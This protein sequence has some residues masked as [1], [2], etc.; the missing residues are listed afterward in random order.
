MIINV[1]QV[2]Y[3]IKGKKIGF[4]KEGFK[5]MDEEVVRVVRQVVLILEEVGVE[6]FD[7]FFFIYNDGEFFLYYLIGC[8]VFFFDWQV[9]IY[10]IKVK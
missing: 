5:D 10:V 2:N 6:V 9:N 1:V 3:G 4:F 7:V 8:I